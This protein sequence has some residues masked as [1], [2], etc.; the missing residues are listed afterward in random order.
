VVPNWKSDKE[1]PIYKYVPSSEQPFTND[2]EVLFNADL[3]AKL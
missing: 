2:S 3:H 1:N